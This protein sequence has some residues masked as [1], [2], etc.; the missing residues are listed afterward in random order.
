MFEKG[1]KVKIISHSRFL[2]GD[3]VEIISD[4]IGDD[5]YRCKRT[6]GSQLEYYVKECQMQ[7]I[8]EK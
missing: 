3:I 8:E 4:K 2:E 7:P 5:E 6:G 1:Q